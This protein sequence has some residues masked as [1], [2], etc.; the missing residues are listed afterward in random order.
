MRPRTLAAV[1]TAALLACS[2][3]APA[4]AENWIKP[5]FTKR[6]L[7]RGVNASLAKGAQVVHINQMRTRDARLI[8]PTQYGESCFLVVKQAPGASGQVV[9]TA[10]LWGVNSCRWESA[11]HQQLKPQPRGAARS[12]RIA[13]LPTQLTS[14]TTLPAFTEIVGYGRD[15]PGT[16]GTNGSYWPYRSS[17]ARVLAEFNVQE[18]QGV[19]ND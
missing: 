18:V 11:R 19:S 2:L 5:T 4:R 1:T 14:T 16:S 3:T 15:I 8:A 10:E 12:R 13:T 7:L 9:R 17:Y 6:F